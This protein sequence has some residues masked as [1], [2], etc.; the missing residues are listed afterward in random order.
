[1]TKLNLLTFDI[2]AARAGWQCPAC[3]LCQACRQPG[4]ESKLLSCD[5]CD[6]AYHIF[7]IRPALSSIPKHSWKCKVCIS[8]FVLEPLFL[9]IVRLFSRFFKQQGS[10]QIVPYSFQMCRICTDCGARTPGSGPSSRW[11]ANFSVCDSCYQQ[12]NKGLACPL[13]GKAYRHVAQKLMLQ[14]HL[15]KKLVLTICLIVYANE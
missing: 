2:V 6:K 3:K 1:M 11:H 5:T 10:F 9:L 12:R 13:C 8:F 14:C 7:C 15:C 4:D